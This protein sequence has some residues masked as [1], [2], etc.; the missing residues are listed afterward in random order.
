MATNLL[1]ILEIASRKVS[2]RRKIKW[3]IHEIYADESRYNKNGIC[4]LEEYVK[5]NL[6]TVKDMPICVE[7]MDWDKSEPWGHGLSGVTKD[8]QPLFEYSVVVGTTTNAY[9]DDVE[10]NGKTIRALIG[11]G[12]L[13][14]QRY[15]KFVKWV[16]SQLFDGEF[17]DTSVEI[18]AKSSDGYEEIIYATGWK[19]KGR[20]PKIFDYTGSAILGVEPADDNAV[21]LELNAKEDNEM[22]KEKIIELNNTINEKDN[23]IKELEA[24]IN[25]KGGEID[26]L[27]VNIGEKD[28]KIAELNTTI[29]TKDSEIESLT[30]EINELKEFKANIEKENL[31]ADLNDKLAKYP[32]EMN[33]LV[34]DKVEAFKS[35]PT[36]AGIQ[37]IVNEINAKLVEKILAEQFNKTKVNEQNSVEDIFGDVDTPEK[38]TSD[39]DMSDIF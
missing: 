32:A 38:E 24:E 9:I 17:P 5:E 37:E 33:E 14:E 28:A 2:G 19:E 11:E 29:E 39:D 12:V 25:A 13:Y 22:D 18:S 3:I 26:E 20:I 34:K 35:D 23:R 16:K 31:I 8:G 7:F 1:N 21:L 6:E 4:W 10:V 36:E 30:N 27:K 15:P